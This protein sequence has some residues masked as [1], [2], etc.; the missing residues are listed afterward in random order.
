V[1][2]SDAAQ[3]LT[4]QELVSASERWGFC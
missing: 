1:A 4:E 2:C 3:Q